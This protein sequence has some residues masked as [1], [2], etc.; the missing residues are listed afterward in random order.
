MEGFL[1]ITTPDA[2]LA[3]RDRQPEEAQCRDHHYTAS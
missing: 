3:S 2:D 1:R